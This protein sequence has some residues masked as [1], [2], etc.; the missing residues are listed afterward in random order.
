[1]LHSPRVLENCSNLMDGHDADH[2]GLLGQVGDV[3]HYRVRGGTIQAR[4][5]FVEKEHLGLC[6]KRPVRGTTMFHIGG[7][8]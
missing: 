7:W 6:L 1:M 2:L 5:R 4:R 3:L 8:V